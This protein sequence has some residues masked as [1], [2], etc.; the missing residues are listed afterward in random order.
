[1]TTQNRIIR[2]GLL[3]FIGFASSFN[4]TAQK[5]TV[6]NDLNFPRTEVVSIP[7]PN[8]QRLLLQYSAK[9]IRIR[10]EGSTTYTT[11]QWIDNN[12]D[13]ISD[14]LIFLADV[15]ANGI[16]NYLV[17]SDTVPLPKIPETETQTYSRFVPERTDD[18]TWEND[19]VA[20]RVY[21]PKGQQE[22]LKGIAG[23]TLSSGVDLWLKRVPYPIINKW[24]KKHLATPGYYHTDR[25]EGY[26]PYHVGNSR[27]TG[28]IGVWVKDS[29]QVSQNYNSYKTI[30]TGPLRTVFQLTYAPWSDYALQQTSTVSLDLGSNFTRFDISFKGPRRTPNYTIGISLHQNKG[31]A[32]LNKN[33]GWFRHWEAIDD[34]FIGEGIVIDPTSITSAF[35]N[36]SKTPDQSNL[37]IITKPLNRLVYYAGFAWQKSGQIKS[38][39]DWD[40][41][42]E[43]QSLIIR[44]PLKVR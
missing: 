23:S 20:F 11:L 41:I 44:N 32:L 29:L 28:G 34:S 19:R 13:G 10:K 36:I 25:G 37:L 8:L 17:L 9:N 43:K 3:F 39:E 40:T 5:L 1:M 26:D 2:T 33:R 7:S 30:A 35:T 27:G 21:G 12:Q 31:E 16:T 15:A 42:L 14:E 6:T 38:K 18:Y 4:C 24:Y 22:A